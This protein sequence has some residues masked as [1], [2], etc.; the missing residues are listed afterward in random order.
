M[1]HHFLLAALINLI[2][3]AGCGAESAGAPAVPTANPLVYKA[4]YFSDGPGELIVADLKTHSEVF[5]A[6]TFDEFKSLAGSK[7]ALWV[8]RNAVEM[9]DMDWLNLPPQKYYPLVIVGYN[10]PLYC[11]REILPVGQIEGPYVDWG[12]E[13]L[14]PGFC[15]WMIR[16]E[17]DS[18]QEAFFQGYHQAPVVQDILDVTNLLLEKHQ[19][20]Q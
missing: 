14:Q 19:D 18:G 6:L 12:Q 2:L 4:V 10:D 16:I 13:T 20:N 11:F 5:V 9:I 8:D 1:K 7:I 15:A 17:S 3:L